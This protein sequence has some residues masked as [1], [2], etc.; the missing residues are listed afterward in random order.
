MS[1]SENKFLEL[2]K[3]SDLVTGDFHFEVRSGDLMDLEII[4]KKFKNCKILNGDFASS[5]FDNC[6]FN[7]VVF[8]ESSLVGLVFKNCQFIECEF[9]NI[10]PDFNLENCDIRKLVITR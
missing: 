6:S 4:N 5:M 3:S 1:N 9:F 7:K 2:L 8:R 10:D